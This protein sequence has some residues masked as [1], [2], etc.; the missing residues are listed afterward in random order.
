MISFMTLFSIFRNSQLQE[1]V[2]FLTNEMDGLQ[3]QMET[4]VETRERENQEGKNLET[5]LQTEVKMARQE[6]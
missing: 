3:S 5:I 6:W 1:K 4:I 2:S